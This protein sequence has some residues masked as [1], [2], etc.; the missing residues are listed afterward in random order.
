[1]NELNSDQFLQKVKPHYRRDIRLRAAE[2]DVRRCFWWVG[3]SHGK[4]IFGPWRR[5]EDILHPS[6]LDAIFFKM[7]VD[8]QSWDIWRVDSENNPK[9]VISLTYRDLECLATMKKLHDK[10]DYSLSKQWNDICIKW[11]RIWWQELERQNG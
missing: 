10:L 7:C 6:G 3:E 4:H 11:I 2:R 9:L 8:Y 5:G 1:M